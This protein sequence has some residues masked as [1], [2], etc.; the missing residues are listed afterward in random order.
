M[1]STIQNQSGV[2]FG[3]PANAREVTPGTEW[4]VNFGALTNAK[5]QKCGRAD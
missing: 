2:Q 3:F 1:I 5:R 4:P